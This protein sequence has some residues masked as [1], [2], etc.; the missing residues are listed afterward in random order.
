MNIDG[1]EVVKNLSYSSSSR[2]KLQS[3]LNESTTASALLGDESHY[4]PINSNILRVIKLIRSS[5]VITRCLLN[6]G[7]V[8]C[9]N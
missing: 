2:R 8:S 9:H 3:C 5:A 6:S 7:S 1:E 4:I